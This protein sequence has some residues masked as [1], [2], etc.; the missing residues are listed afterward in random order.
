MFKLEDN[1]EELKKEFKSRKEVYEKKSNLTQEQVNADIAADP[2]WE[3]DGENSKGKKLKK[4]LSK[5]W[6]FEN[7]VW[8]FFYHLGCDFLNTGGPNKY[9]F[10]YTKKNGD[11]DREQLDVVAIKDRYV[12]ICEATAAKQKTKYGQQQKKK[13]DA[14]LANRAEIEKEIFMGKLRKRKTAII[15]GIL[16]LFNFDNFELIAV[17]IDIK[18]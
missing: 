12:F 10:E 9:S 17:W 1:E 16:A 15:F 13:I 6:I 7:E 8:S 3:P 4:K 2:S 18:F 11:K 5:E 14:K